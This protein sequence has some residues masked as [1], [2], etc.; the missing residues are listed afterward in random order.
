MFIEPRL[1][2]VAYGYILVCPTQRSEKF[3]SN[4]LHG[5]RKIFYVNIQISDCIWKGQRS[6]D[7]GL[8]SCRVSGP[9]FDW[10]MWASVGRNSHW[11]FCMSGNNF[12]SWSVKKV[13]LQEMEWSD[14]CA[15]QYGS[16]W[17][18]VVEALK[19]SWYDWETEF[20]I[21]ANLNSIV[22]TKALLGCLGAS[23]G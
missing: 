20:Q 5:K 1:Q 17:S 8:H 4:C 18:C 12:F 7:T 21:L 16:P 10:G 15:V 2:R 6:L 23:V 14:T 3:H 9:H 19:C 13:K 22:K 11:E